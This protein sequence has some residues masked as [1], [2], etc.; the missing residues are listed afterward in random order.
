MVWFPTVPSLEAAY[1]HDSFAAINKMGIRASTL[2]TRALYRSTE[3]EAQLFHQF[4]IVPMLCL[5]FFRLIGTCWSRHLSW[6][7]T[8]AKENEKEWPGKRACSAAVHLR[9]RSY[10]SH[11]FR[12]MLLIVVQA[13]ISRAIRQLPQLTCHLNNIPPTRIQRLPRKLTIA[14]LQWLLVKPRIKRA[15]VDSII[16]HRRLRRDSSP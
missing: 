5:L 3:V 6:I 15:R 16:A 8:A 14:H 11:H 9:C 12:W 4:K 13:C 2:S 1:L 10:D 7:T